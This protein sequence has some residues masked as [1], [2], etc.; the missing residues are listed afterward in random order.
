MAKKA[1]R[2]AR[3]GAQQ[4]Q[5]T[6]VQQKPVSGQT[7]GKNSGIEQKQSFLQRYADVIIPLGIAVLVWLFFGPCGDNQFTNWDDPGYIKDNAL[8]KDVSWE[9]IKN[10]FSVDNAVMGNYHPI[11][12]L[13]YGIEYSFARL[14]PERYHVDSVLFHMIVTM[15][16]FWFV[17]V[18]TRRRIAAAIAAL[19][20]GL[21]PMHVESVAWIAGRKDV[22]YGMFYMAACVAHVYYMR[23][24]SSGRWKQYAAVLLLFVCALLAKP[25]A[26]VLPL[27]LLLID[28]FEQRPMKWNLLTEKI[29][30][31]VLAVLCGIQSLHDQHAFKALDTHTNTYSFLE[32]I[33]LGGYAFITYLWKAVVPVGLCNFYPY[34]EQENGVIPGAYYMY[35]L[36]ALLLIVALGMFAR[37]NRVIVFGSLLFLVNI[38]L[39][40]QFLPVGGA[41]L[42]DRYTYIPYLGLFFIV[43]WY[44]AGFFEAGGNRQ[45]G[46]IILTGSVVYSLVLGYLSNERCRVWYDTVSLWKDEIEKEPRRVPQAWNNLGFEYFNRFNDAVNP[47]QKK[48]Y[49]DSSAMLLG[50]AIELQPTFANPYVSLGELQR[51][52]GKFYEAR[53]NY[54]TALRLKGSDKEADAY[55]GLGIIYAISHN[56]DSAAICF[57][58]AIRMKPYYPEAHG[59]FGNYYDMIGKRDSALVHYSIAIKQNPDMFAP[60]LNRARLYQKMNRFKEA[61]DDF[62][63]ALQLS[64]D[65]GEVYFSRG[66]CEGEMGNYQAGWQD[67]E[68]ARSLG[69][70]VNNGLYD[71]MRRRVGK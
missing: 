70:N 59:N 40:L 64:P 28:Y 3:T 24:G 56:F 35:P 51:S 1:N 15:L 13:T 20:F 9:G 31:F 14:N 43:G 54:Y 37:K 49:Y 10:I 26:V 16:V 27:T 23:A 45:L 67:M 30:H 22:V 41:I 68:K 46:T 2:A 71:A 21:H 33:A 42:A 58:S 47:Q 6:P 39:L 32:R 12:I 5:R 18:L 4:A 17:N 7:P 61:L 66:V 11:T 60:Y 25:V 63:I 34:P 55:L 62:A 38:V 50:K 8:I 65:N 48:I 57:S 53:A 44:V 36:A 29:P 19:L 52:V 69:F